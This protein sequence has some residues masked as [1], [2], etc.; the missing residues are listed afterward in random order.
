MTVY[1]IPGQ[2]PRPPHISGTPDAA[3]VGIAY[4]FTP[5]VTGGN[6]PFAFASVGHLLPDGLSFDPLTGTISGTPTTAQDV[7]NIAITVT[8]AAR[9]SA[10][11]SGLEINVAAALSVSGTPVTTATQNVAYA[12]FTVAGADG[13]A[14]Y[15]YTVHAGTL[16]TGI[17]LDGGTGDVAGTPTVVETKTG[18]V[19]RATDALGATADLPAFQIAVTA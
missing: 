1:L 6:P 5:T 19:I 12:G 8:D 9:L 17:T 10:T 14:P 15:A 18:I 2:A 13:V 7:T 11:L 16:P 4:T 3:E